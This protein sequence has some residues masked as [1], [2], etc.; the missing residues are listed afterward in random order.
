MFS[1]Y[2]IKQEYKNV[3]LTEYTVYTFFMGSNLQ[4]PIFDKETKL[5]ITLR[6]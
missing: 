6:G 3:F 4:K 1:C 2:A 5:R